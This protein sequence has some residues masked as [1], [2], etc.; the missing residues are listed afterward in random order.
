MFAEKLT[1]AGSGVLQETPQVDSGV[2]ILCG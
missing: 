1:V 2:T